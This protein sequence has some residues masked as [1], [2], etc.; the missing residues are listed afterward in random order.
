MVRPAL[1]ALSRRI[2]SRSM[3]EK[4]KKGFRRFR[5]MTAPPDKVFYKPEG[6]KPFKVLKVSTYCFKAVYLDSGLYYSLSPNEMIVE[7]V[8]ENSENETEGSTEMKQGKLY[9]INENTFGHYMATNDKGWF[10]LE[11]EGKYSAYDPET[12]QEVLPW[13]FEAKDTTGQTK[14]FVGSKDMV[15]KGDLIYNGSG[16]FYLVTATDTKNPK[17]EHKFIGQRVLTEELK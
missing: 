9:Q 3:S 5:V 14:F 8:L 4:W 15:S 2:A 13:S 16:M 1:I 10:V 7:A 12:V 11:V 17:A 6:S